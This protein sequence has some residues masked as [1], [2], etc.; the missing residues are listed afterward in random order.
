[1]ASSHHSPTVPFSPCKYYSD[2]IP[3]VIDDHIMLSIQISLVIIVRG[4]VSLSGVISNFTNAIVFL[5]LGLK[6]SMTVG[7]FALS[8]TDCLV[9]LLQVSSCMCYL[10]QSL[11]PRSPI[12]LW[13]LGYFVFGW[14]I[15]SMYQVSCWITV[16]VSL[17]RCICVVSPFKVKQ[18]FTRLRCALAI[19]VIYVIHISLYLPI[20]IS[21]KM[22][23]VNE[24]PSST[25]MNSTGVI[26]QVLTVIFNEETAYFEIIF[27]L[28]IGVA[29]LL[30][31]HAIVISSALLMAS[32]LKAST[33]VR[34]HG[35]VNSLGK[36]QG[37]L[38]VSNM[39]NRERRLLKVVLFLALNLTLC[40]IPRYITLTVYHT[41][42]GMNTGRQGNLSTVM[43]TIT[44]IFSTLC[45]SFNLFVYLALN[46]KFRRTFLK[47]MAIYDKEAK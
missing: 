4:C 22:D 19:L 27:D 5:K 17:E 33:S 21:H 23:W 45:C 2:D 39:T 35:T 15:N 42:P 41:L 20:F 1:M 28:T 47:C 40:N 25:A 46:S 36:D 26:I 44:A 38:P 13:A 16:T 9:T 30:L 7:L 11:Y 6:D 8:F 32:S 34:G 29:W 24:T 14:I 10:A 12:N 31:S 37:Q 18:I 3:Q 43:W